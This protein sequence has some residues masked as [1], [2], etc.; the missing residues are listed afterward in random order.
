MSEGIKAQYR[1]LTELKRTEEKIHRLKAELDRIPQELSDL[2]KKISNHQEGFNAAK[3][4]CDGQEKALRKAEADLKEKDDFLRK[5]ES[6][7]MEVKTNEEY[8]AAQK[9]NEIHK[10]EKALLEERVMSAMNVLEEA[11]K[12]LS[13]AE[14]EFNSQTG[15]LTGEKSKLQE[16]GKSLNKSYE[17]L[18]EKRKASVAQLDS[19]TASLYTRVLNVMKSGIPIVKAENGMCM[20]CNMKVRP[21]LYNE[22]L[23]YKAI[24]RCPSCGRILV[25]ADVEE[26]T[27]ETVAS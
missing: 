10:Q 25:I 18:L 6:K 4:F 9:E 22:I 11:R 23:G 20:G 8:Q 2:D 16:E 14:S 1:T 26:A 13:V 24:H 5:A 21:Q 12:R 27:A 15:T 3:L 7:M 17:E 19:S